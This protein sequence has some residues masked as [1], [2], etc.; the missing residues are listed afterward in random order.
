M[1]KRTGGCHCGAVRFSVIGPVREVIYCHCEQCRRQSGHFVAATACD[2]DLLSVSG[3]EN[4]TW[5]AASD[6]AKRAFCKTCG[7]LLFWKANGGSRTSIMAGAFDKPT[8]LVAGHHI[9]IA[10]KGDYYEIADG[11]PQYQ[12]R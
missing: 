6:V 10:D 3:A 12:E 5:Y 2:D 8:G 4:L 9:H 11:L 7:S 1:E